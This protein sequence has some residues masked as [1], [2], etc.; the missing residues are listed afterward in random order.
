MS[1]DTP[2]Y[3]H[4]LVFL[5]DSGVGKTS[6]VERYVYNS[7]SMYT[8]RTI[9]A[10]LH[11]KTVIVDGSRIKLVIWDLG[12]QES[13]S[14]LREQYCSNAAGA[15][16][17][18]DITRPETLANID[19][20]LNAL[21]SGAGKVPVI[22]VANKIDLSPVITDDQLAGLAEVRGLKLIRTSATENENVDLAFLELVK[23]IQEK[24][25]TR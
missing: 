5:G 24:F 8:G 25:K 21:Y 23:S 3:V 22:M 16:L 18:V 19:R 4:K 13:F 1:T 2:D 9:G 20:W 11:V 17:V 7:L 6:L 12:G 14:A 15:F 10:I